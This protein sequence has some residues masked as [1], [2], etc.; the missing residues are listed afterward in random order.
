MEK[1]NATPHTYPVLVLPIQQLSTV[2][3]VLYVPFVSRHVLMLAS[4]YVL[5]FLCHLDVV[6][7]MLIHRYHRCIIHTISFFGYRVNI[8]FVILEIHYFACMF[9][10]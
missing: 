2:S 7:S 6:D 8:G 5:C 4:G 9:S 10:M 3:L 1:A